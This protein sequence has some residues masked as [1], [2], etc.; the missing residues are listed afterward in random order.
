[1]HEL[2]TIYY[3]IDTVEQLMVENQLTKVGSITLQ[4]GEVS[5]I[6]P[7]YLQEFWEYARKK[8][9]HFQETELIIEKLEAVTYC[10]DCGKTY[11]T[12]Q[13]KK[14]CPCCGSGNTFLVTGNEYIIKEI[15]AM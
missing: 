14:I 2:G 3:V 6:I 13:Y 4:V 1:M 12:M 9:E 15:E 8:T 11:S 10:Q 7:E 5:G